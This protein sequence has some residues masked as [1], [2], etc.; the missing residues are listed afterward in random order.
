MQ[1]QTRVSFSLKEKK[2]IKRVLDQF[3]QHIRDAMVRDAL[4]IR[5]DSPYNN[6]VGCCNCGDLEPTYKTLR[7]LEKMFGLIKNSE[8]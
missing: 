2:K 3:Q 5:V 7:N 1:N 8:A 6:E 4:G